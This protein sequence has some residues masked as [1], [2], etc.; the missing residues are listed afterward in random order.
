MSMSSLDVGITMENAAG[1]TD[2][3]QAATAEPAPGAARGDN[4]RGIF[5]NLG[6]HKEAQARDL[7]TDVSPFRLQA[8]FDFLDDHRKGFLSATA[9]ENQLGGVA[10]MDEVAALMKMVSGMEGEFFTTYT[11]TL[12]NTVRGTL[13]PTIYIQY[14][15]MQ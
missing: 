5:V 1:A 14:Y 15:G 10:D 9:L 8:A 12:V 11:V 4:S 7:A 13:S 2:T 3:S 6:A